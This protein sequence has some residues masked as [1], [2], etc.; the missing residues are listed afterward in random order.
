MSMLFETPDSPKRPI[1]R[2][3][4]SVSKKIEA[5]SLFDQLGNKAK[6]AKE[7]KVERSLVTKW[8]NQRDVLMEL[9]YRKNMS[10]KK[11]LTCGGRQAFFPEL[12][13]AVYQ[14]LILRA[15]IN[16]ENQEGDESDEDDNYEICIDNILEIEK[17]MVGNQ[18]ETDE[19]FESNFTRL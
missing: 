19:D 13:L 17:L 10:N 15:D 2:Q 7:L 11:R 6:V 12:E 14:W 8:V 5:I 18:E 9:G 1:P 4:H 3:T 16:D